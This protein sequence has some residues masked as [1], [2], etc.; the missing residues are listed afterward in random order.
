LAAEGVGRLRPRALLYLAVCFPLATGLVYGAL[1][2]VREP[3]VARL[4]ARIA[5]PDPVPPVPDDPIAA[6][7]LPKP[8]PQD[9]AAAPAKARAIW[10]DLVESTRPG[11]PRVFVP[12]A[13]IVAAAL[14]ARRPRLLALAVVA[15]LWAFGH[16]LHPRVP[17]AE[18]RARPRWLAGVM[19]EPGGP[20]LSVL[21]RRVD[22]ALDTQLLSS[23][24]GLLWGTSDPFVPSP[25]FMLAND[26]VLATAGLDVGEKGATHVGRNVAGRAVAR[27]MG[28]R[29]IVS[30]H[31]VPG[32]TPVVIGPVNVYAD[33]EALPRVRVVPCVAAATSQA[34]A[35][36]ALPAL[37]SR[38]VVIE[39][40][41]PGCVEGGGAVVEAWSDTEV[42]VR[43]TGPGTLVVADTWYPG[44]VAKIDGEPAPIARADA[45][46]RA[47]TLPPGEHAVTLRYA[48][49]ARR[50]LWVG[51]AAAACATFAAWSRATRSAS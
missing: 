36:L 6:A 30:V 12:V 19:T 38:T 51:L 13:L 39:G 5:R 37:D 35:F 2:V 47:V 40:G 16:D 25:L 41:S 10:R 43:A 48:P 21:D 42:A 46:F 18:T 15:D 11:S 32:L 3:L 28:V 26:A 20:R 17:A 31:E 27:R 4:E 23:S 1:H 50:L 9:P 24:L 8:E 22:P 45:I 33:R 34:E 7:A 29:W 44:W 14:F 49:D